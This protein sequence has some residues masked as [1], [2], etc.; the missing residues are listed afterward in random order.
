M[1]KIVALDKP[2]KRVLLMGNE[3]IARGAIEAGIHYATS[4][5]GTPS[6]EIMGTLCKVAKELEFHAEWSTNEKVAFE[7]AAAASFAGL[8]AITSMKNVGLNWA[9]DMLL[10]INLSGSN[11]GLVIISA[12]DPG[13][14]SSTN[15]QDNR[16][17]GK[18]AEVP[19]MEPSSQQEAKD[20]VKFA[21]E[22][23][24]LVKL[25][26]LIRGTTRLTH[27]RGDVVL[28]EIEKIRRKPK[29]EGPFSSFPSSPGKHNVL[30]EKVEKAKEILEK[31]EFNTYEG[32]GDEEFIIITSGTGYS[33]TKEVFATLGLEKVGILKLGTLFPLPE[34]LIKKHLSH[35]KKVLFVEEVDPYLEDD[36]RSIAVDLEKDKIPDKFYG[37]KTG[38]IPSVHELTPDIIL[39]AIAKI[40]G[41]EYQARDPEYVSKTKKGLQIVPPRTL[42]LCPGC[43]HRASFYAV[44]MAIRKNKSG[45]CTGDIGCY[46]LG[47]LPP[48]KINSTVHCMGAGVGLGVGFGQIEDL[49]NG[50]VIAFAGDGTFYHACVPAIINAVYNQSPAKIMVLDNMI[51]AM[52]GLQ[53]HPGTGKTAVGDL[54]TEIKIEDICKGVGVKDIRI[55]D[56][57]NVKEAIKVIY[58]AMNT[59]ELTV[60]ISRHM[61]T[62]EETKLKKM[63]GERFKEFQVDLDKCTGCKICTEQFSCPALVWLEDEE[64]VKIDDILCVGCAVCAD[65]CPYRA[66]GEVVY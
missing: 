37:K 9:S 51:T 28:G 49:E 44:K 38:H 57:F 65:V 43:P 4:Y 62:L 39:N 31:S 66:I 45:F 12:D 60:I 21:F 16:V 61:C 30:H 3:A 13:G 53:P 50:P 25:P 23:S 33:Y 41:I 59:P 48:F 20:M 15:E 27:S 35:A 1:S 55:I 22:L 26:V 63:R 34:D 2:G 10:T 36:I 6:S 24:E 42:T 46:T 54:T 8:R 29:F 18:F 40:E 47:V 56:P 64:K 32:N 19:T 11:G 5:P 7:G 58:D 52:T 14:H 17:Y